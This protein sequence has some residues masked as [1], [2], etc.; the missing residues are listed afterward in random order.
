MAAPD[1]TPAVPPQLCAAGRRVAGRGK[2]AAPVA[3]GLGQF[4]LLFTEPEATK[5]E[6]ESEAPIQAKTEQP[7]TPPQR[8]LW[9]VAELVGALRGKIEREFADVWVQGEI[10]N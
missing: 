2:P 7:A 4:G 8:K 10:S 6:A 1:G 5:L 3:D 9:A